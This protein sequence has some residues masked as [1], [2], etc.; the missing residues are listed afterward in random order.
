MRDSALLMDYYALTMAN[1]Y[2]EFKP[3]A[4]ATFDLFLR[5]LPPN[6]N[7]VIACGIEESLNYLKDFSFSKEDLE[8]L[9]RSGFNKGFLKYLA[10][11]KFRGDVW[12]VREGTV[13]FAQEPI[14]RIT[15]PLVQAQLVEAFLL[16]TVNVLTMVASKA[17]RVVLA[18]QNK[19]VFDF[20]LRRAQ[21]AGASLKA[22]KAS[23]ISGFSGTSNVL[24]GKL[25]NI[26]VVGTMAHSYVMAF[27]SEVE[28]F[29]AY[30]DVFPN[31]SILLV[32]T[33]NYAHGI[34]NAIAVANRLK[35]KGFKL[36]AVRLDSGDLVKISRKIR[37]LLDKNGLSFVKIFAS[38]NLDEY[39]I[40]KLIKQDAKIDSFGVGTNMGVSADA[41]YCD[42]IYKI[43]ETTNKNG[44]FL[45]TIKLS[46]NKSTYPG[47]KQIYRISSKKGKF[48][49]DV[50]ALEA[51]QLKGTALL[52]QVMDEGKKIQDFSNIEKTK[53]YVKWQ[54]SCL[55]DCYKTVKAS[56]EYPVIKSSRLKKL[57][58][59][60]TKKLNK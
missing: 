28:S 24:A 52:S 41:P 36:Q 48:M 55:P 44:R 16:N 58:N 34:K 29:K 27:N 47:R 46:A 11:L 56:K 20:S 9:K 15:A 32:D 57:K 50:L 12:A 8:Y 33:Y 59:S 21:G 17:A 53:A 4:L 35:L 30:A 45:P 10:K 39:K 3:N 19:P 6:R 60:L 42:V 51:E 13:I 49:K 40:E 43:S 14:L 22:A 37:K 31:R 7:F 2:Y 25:F 5:S 54:L 26:N 18:A 38:G 1:V 23:Y